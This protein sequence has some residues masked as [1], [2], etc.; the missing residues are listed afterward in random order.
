MREEGK[1]MKKV[2]VMISG[3]F[4]LLLSA[5]GCGEEPKEKEGN[6]IY[7]EET[8]IPLPE[9][10]EMLYDIYEDGGVSVLG[11]AGNGIGT[12]SYSEKDKSWEQ[13]NEPWEELSDSVVID[14]KAFNED[15]IYVSVLKDA[16]LTQDK[17][18]WSQLAVKYYVLQKDGGMK[19]IPME[20]PTEDDQQ[21]KNIFQCMI[22]DEDMLIGKDNSD[23]IYCFS[24]DGQQ[25]YKIE[26]TESINGMVKVDG[27]LYVAFS[28]QEIL[29]LDAKSGKPADGE[30]KI[31]QFLEVSDGEYAIRGTK[32][33]IYKI[34]SKKMYRYDLEKKTSEQLLDFSHYGLKN[35]YNFKIMPDENGDIYVLYLLQ[36]GTYVLGKY[37]Y[38]E[39][40][41]EVKA[42]AFTIYSLK[43]NY[44]LQR[45]VDLFSAK[46]PEI[47]IEIK[48]GLSGEDGTTKAD[49]LKLLNTELLAGKG[50]DLLLLDDLPVESYIREGMLKDLNE[51]TDMDTLSDDLF[52]NMLEP[53]ADEKGQ[54]A[55]P[56]GFLL[57]GIVG[58]EEYVNSFADTD[59]FLTLAENTGLPFA[60]HDYNLSE[61]ANIIYLQHA[62]ECFRDD[63]TADQEKLKELYSYFDRVYRIS[64]NSFGE[65]LQE[66][67]I[68]NGWEINSMD[69][70]IEW[71]YY[72]K[73]PFVMAPYMSSDGL[74]AAKFLEDEQGYSCGYLEEEGELLYNDRMIFG[75]PENTEQEETAGKFIEFVL[76]EGLR[77]ASS[78]LMILPV[79]P[80]VL[81]AQ[82]KQSLD[83]KD[84]YTIS[85]FGYESDSEM[86]DVKGK[87]WK[88]EE[89]KKLQEK[90]ST[91]KKVKYAEAEVREMVID[92]ANDYCLGKKTLDVSAEDTARTLTLRNQ[93]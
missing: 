66:D 46:Y 3:F 80:T 13:T 36:D 56:C 70:A 81:E 43:E 48:Y 27:L 69:R 22:C 59:D 17:E 72:D 85:S 50:Y 44:G 16:M 6:K 35:G 75:V 53:Y 32:E 77:K 87:T 11:D 39:E 26:E 71:I 5:A 90:I 7:Y 38:K 45:Q 61:T 20:L 52:K 47:R 55:V 37:I 93:E 88:E 10:T 14:A 92:G 57:Y 42:E 65:E 25:K 64:G 82:L 49:A 4:L 15:V 40:G 74:K 23:S 41:I 58:K 63:G 73:L 9:G 78:N 89:C 79:N 34:N 29:C 51:I 33:S 31:K 54:Y 24:L 86:T 62:S 2:L 21:Q 91:A 28:S 1:S 60:V 67:G 84:I 76:K 83:G 8:N 68:G 12:F 19:E 30:E 18:A